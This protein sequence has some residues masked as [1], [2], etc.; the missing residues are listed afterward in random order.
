MKLDARIREICLLKDNEAAKLGARIREIRKSKGINQQ[1][2]VNKMG[3]YTTWL[4][5]I[6][7]GNRKISLI[8]LMGIADILQVPISEFFLPKNIANSK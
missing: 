6:E 2:I 7:Y 5:A 1:F 3:K 8:D 4:T